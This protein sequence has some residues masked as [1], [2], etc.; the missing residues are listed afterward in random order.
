MAFLGLFSLLVLQSL[1]L[2]TTFTDETIAE[3]SVNMY[4]HLRATGEDENILFSP[5]SVTL[6]MGMLELGAQGSTLKEIRHSMGYDSLRNGEEFSFLKDL[7]HMVTAEDSQYVMK[8]ANSLFVQNG[9]HIIFFPGEFYGQR[10]L[11]G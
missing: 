5:L 11:E 7:S 10:S 2:G 4:N 6:A 9:F 8:I 1:A 3:L